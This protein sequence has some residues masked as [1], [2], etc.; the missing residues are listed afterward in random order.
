M[1]INKNISHASATATSGIST[2]DIWNSKFWL[3]SPKFDLLLVTGGAFF[4][5]LIA[6]TAFQV[7]QLLPLFFW[8]WVIAFEGSHFWATFSRTYIDKKFRAENSSVLYG[9]LIFF[10]FPALA[11]FL[12]MNQE[13]VSFKTLY[14]FF[15]FIWSLYHNARQHYGFLSIYTGKAQIPDNLKEKM[16][17]TLYLGVATA[18]IYFLLN[19]KTPLAFG[20]QSLNIENPSLNFLVSKFPMIFSAVVFLYLLY[21]TRETVTKVGSSS[22]ISLYYIATCWIFYSAMFYYI[23]PQDHFFKNASGGETLMLI[24]IMNSLFHNIQYHAIVWYYGNKRFNENNSSENKFGIA[25]FVNY[26]TQNY[27]AFSILLGFVFGLIVWNVGDWPDFRGSWDNVTSY[28]WAYILFFG[29]IG[30]HFY[31][32]QKIWRPS[33][34]KELRSYLNLSKLPS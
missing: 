12:D 33:K 18:Q 14:G 10:V 2:N 31:L 22:L 4:T 21:L 5:L 23:A 25:R 32:D 11:V 13:D 19:F 30:H 8:I 17:R 3:F 24:A 26:K 28:N 16:V 9:S 1:I 6:A 27:L 20:M 15:I 34:S 7:P 29:I